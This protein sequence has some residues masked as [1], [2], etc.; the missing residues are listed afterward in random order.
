[1]YILLS[2]FSVFNY[3][4][5]RARHNYYIC[6]ASSGCDAKNSLIFC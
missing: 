1:M 2:V 6:L 4:S 5:F 3:L